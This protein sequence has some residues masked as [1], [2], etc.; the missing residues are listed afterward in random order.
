MRFIIFRKIYT[1]IISD[2]QY[3]C[4]HIH[5]M[6]H[7]VFIWYP[8]YLCSEHASD[9][10]YCLCTWMVGWFYVSNLTWHVQL[11]LTKGEC[12]LSLLYIPSHQIILYLI[13]GDTSTLVYWSRSRP[14]ICDHDQPMSYS[15]TWLNS[16][17]N[18]I[19]IG[20]KLWSSYSNTHKDTPIYTHEPNY[21]KRDF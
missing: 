3:L 15:V 4:W 9:F 14:E 1:G 6:V 18:L 2:T 10:M 19:T 5:D 17:A 20:Q 12:H 8:S 13:I 11:I 21:I 16:Q 7:N